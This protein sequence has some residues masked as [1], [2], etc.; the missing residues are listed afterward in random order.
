MFAKCKN[1]HFQ[2][3]DHIFGQRYVG[4]TLSLVHPASLLSDLSRNKSII[5]RA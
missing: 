4:G 3:L 5:A 2:L 1:T